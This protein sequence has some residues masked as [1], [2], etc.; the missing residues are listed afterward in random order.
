[1]AAEFRISFDELARQSE[2]DELR[3]EVEALRRGDPLN[4]VRSELDP[5]AREINAGVNDTRGVH[6]TPSV[7]DRNHAAFEA[8]VAEANGEAA[9]GGP[10]YAVVRVDAPAEPTDPSKRAARRRGA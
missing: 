6:D 8:A 4:P 1:M 2:L 5:I 10:L 3:R 7:T 9:G